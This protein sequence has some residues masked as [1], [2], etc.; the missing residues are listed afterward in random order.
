MI[1][2][3]TM[4]DSHSHTSQITLN[5]A[6]ATARHGL[7]RAEPP[8]HVQ[9]QL[10]AAFERERGAVVPKPAQP[11]KAPSRWARA[12]RVL[13][14]SSGGMGTA[15]AAF[16]A[17]A[18]FTPYSMLPAEPTQA[19]A[20]SAAGI[21]GGDNAQFLVLASRA[22]IEAEKRA[23]PSAWVMPGE[24]SGN[25]LAELGLPF[26]P[27]RAAEPQRAEL[28]VASSGDVLGVRLAN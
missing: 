9:A 15:F 4:N 3:P 19:V 23:W 28:L 16:M 27:A 6:L 25:Q 12:G 24:V 17:W 7:N 2:T 18:L 11:A 1:K 10:L 14:L 26:D 13:A 20:M 5:S 22:S 21:S 8:A